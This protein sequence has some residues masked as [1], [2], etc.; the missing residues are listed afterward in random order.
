[1]LVAHIQQIYEARGNDRA[2]A[3]AAVNEIIELLRGNYDLLVPVLEALGD[4][5]PALGETTPAPPAR[6]DD[7]I[8]GGF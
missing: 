6:R 1:L 8:W 5:I 4:A 2:W 7:L 3:T